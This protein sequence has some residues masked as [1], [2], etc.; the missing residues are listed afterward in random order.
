LQLG[1]RREKRSALGGACLESF[2]MVE[3]QVEEEGGS[4]V[5]IMREGDV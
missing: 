2:A 4:Y 3:Q 5:S 1:F